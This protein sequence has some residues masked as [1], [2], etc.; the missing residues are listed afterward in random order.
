[1]LSGHEIRELFLRFFEKKD[2][3]VVKSAP[4]I[5]ESDPTLLFVNA[6]M[7]P[8]K[9]V[10]LGI[11]KRPYT[12]AVSCQK[13]LRVSGKHNDLESVGRTSRHHTFF[14]MLGNFS[15]GDYFKKEAILYAWEFVTQVLKL[16]EDRLFVSVYKEDEEAF[17][18][19]LKDVGLKEEKIWR[20]GEEDNFWQMGETG[21]C[22]PSSEIH[23]DRGESYQGDE[24]FL[25]IWNLVFMQYNR[26]ADGKL[27][28]LPK[29]NIDTGMGLERI[30]SVIQGT[31]TNYETDLIKPLIEF[32]QDLAGVTYGIDYEKD[33]ALRVIADHL[34][35]LTFAI[36]DGVIP[37]N[38][39]RGYVI[40]R[41]LR[42]ALRFGYKLNITEAFLHK[43]VDTV[44]SIMSEAYPELKQRAQYI[45]GVIKGEE[46]RFLSTLK[47][48]L[49]I[50]E[51]TIQESLH[52][53]INYI[54]G[55]QV[56]KLYDTYGFPLDILEEIAREKGLYLDME[57]YAKEME[58]QRERARK[59]F[60]IESKQVSPVYTEAKDMGL[61][62][63]FVGYFHYQID[64]EVI[65]IIKDK[66]LVN[67]LREGERGEI[68]LRETP[69][70]PEKGG[71]VGDKGYIQTKEGIFLV[72]DTQTPTEGI[73]THIGKVIRGVINV[74]HKAFASI[75]KER[76]EDIKR[77]HTATH[78]LH[79]ALRNLLGDHV[80]QA[81]SLVSDTYLRF[82]FT[83]FGALSWEEIT[84]IEELVNQQIMKNYQVDIREKPYQEAL[85][86]G[87]IAI[88]EEKYGSTVRVITVGE[89]S[90]E[91]CG[92]THVDRTG[93]IGFFKI[94]SESSI[95]AGI[96]R[97]IAKTGRWALLHTQEEHKLLQDLSES[98][99]IK[100]DDLPQ[101]I[102]RMKESLK[103]KEREI[104]KLKDK[105]AS[106]QLTYNL[107]EE[108]VG[109]A[110]M[111]WCTFSDVE[112]EN[113]R[114]LADNLRNKER[115][116]VFFTAKKENKL[117]TLVAVSKDLAK[118]LPAKDLIKEVGKI[119]GGGGG[120]QEEMAQG[121][122]TKP[123]MVEKAVDKLKEILINV[124]K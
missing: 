86:E 94:I 104:Q 32:G 108:K 82:D 3:T 58:D 61:V 21:P 12:R 9:N 7:V 90:K 95:G 98:M 14:E 26:E 124:L 52:K 66:Q 97:I 53:G 35:A 46:E 56:F 81:G 45:K 54:P 106:L 13:C 105:L 101:A 75:D 38:L 79:A 109:S 63:H 19:W 103:D 10:F 110:I 55:D 51:E 15:F 41:I 80:R 76:R 20:L 64:T 22:G 30:A 40:R 92:G 11:E 49:P 68:L 70:Y 1:M 87:A 18:I 118:L 24:R 60:K 112:V 69:F 34:R 17:N 27:N 65:G 42:R 73:I 25:E 36:G 6:G 83:H 59:H 113:L 89:F 39:G 5:P 115:T 33:T 107:R 37:S 111:Y 123:E 67:Q 43:G 57:G 62:S 31:K 119:I 8:F 102:E 88:F 29:P 77:N 96:R 48:A 120:G 121:G 2:H 72:E 99:G 23:V 122:G 28:P 84:H 44:L 117:S 85:K 47:K 50:V 93:D 16:P 4:L 91:L 78:L 71:Q 74:A 100:I 116:I 114:S